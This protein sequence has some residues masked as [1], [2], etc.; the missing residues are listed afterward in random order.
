[1]EVTMKKITFEIFKDLFVRYPVLDVCRRD[2]EEAFCALEKCY[3]NNGKLLICGNGGSAADAEHIAG[4]LMKG[5]NKKREIPVTDANTIISAFPAEG[6]W[7]ASKLQ[8]ALPAISLASHMALCLAYVN[9][10]SADMVFAQQVYGYGQKGDVLLGLSTS[11]SSQNVIN[12]F[13]I[14]RSMDICTFSMTGKKESDLSA[15]SDISIRVPATETYLVQELHL[16]V[17]H[18]LCAMLESEFF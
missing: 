11:G 12:A 18:A 8:R 17:Y 5:F 1:M 4:E 15:L 7:L 3:S 13:K 2:I 16:P 14:A 6:D 10:V 9:D